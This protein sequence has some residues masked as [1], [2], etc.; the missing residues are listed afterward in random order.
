LVETEE[1]HCLSCWKINSYEEMSRGIDNGAYLQ[2]G[3]VYRQ[4]R[5]VFV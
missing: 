4:V 5:E 3:K 1:E 2:C